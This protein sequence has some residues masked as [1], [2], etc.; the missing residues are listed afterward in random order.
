MFFEKSLRLRPEFRKMG[1]ANKN[2]DFFGLGSLRISWDFFWFCKGN[3]A[4]FGQNRIGF[5]WIFW[6]KILDRSISRPVFRNCDYCGWSDC[7]LGKE[8][9]LFHVIYVQLS[10]N[11]GNGG[12]SRSAT[13]LKKFSSQK[14]QFLAEY[15]LASVSD[16]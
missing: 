4:C 14:V 2:S 12:L 13:I 8:K 5:L 10:K 16:L 9:L 6:F 11:K 7:F 1:R 3:T 15:I